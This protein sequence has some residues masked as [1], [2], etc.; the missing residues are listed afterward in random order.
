MLGRNTVHIGSLPPD[1]ILTLPL[2]V[3]KPRKVSKISI[4]SCNGEVK[5]TSNGSTERRRRMSHWQISWNMS[6]A[7]WLGFI[8]SIITILSGLI[9]VFVIFIPGDKTSSSPALIINETRLVD[10]LFDGYEGS[11]TAE[12]VGSE[13]NGFSICK[14]GYEWLDGKCQLEVS[15]TCPNGTPQSHCFLEDSFKCESCILFYELVEGKCLVPLKLVE[16]D[17]M[18]HV[19]ELWASL[20]YVEEHKDFAMLLLQDHEWYSDFNFRKIWF[21]AVNPR[22]TTYF[23]LHKYLTVYSWI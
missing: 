16:S 3:Q 2:H 5:N 1:K 19:D 18:L 15:C 6:T 21:H 8:G 11:D 14:N 10:L 12:E 20:S 23:K 13:G 22:R 9:A 4:E 17:Y 7:E